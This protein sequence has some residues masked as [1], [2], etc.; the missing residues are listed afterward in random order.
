MFPATRVRCHDLANFLCRSPTLQPSGTPMSAIHH[1]AMRH[2]HEQMLARLHNCLTKAQRASLQLLAQRLSVAAG[3]NGRLGRFKLLLLC[4][5]GRDSV[6]ALIFL[7]AAQLHIAQRQPQTFQLRVAVWRQGGVGQNA[8]D[9]AL[10]AC[11][12][13][14][15]EGD[16]DVEL[17]AVDDQRIGPLHPSVPADDDGRRRQRMNM[18]VSGHLSGGHEWMTF[19]YGSYL[20]MAGCYWRASVWQ[21]GVDAVAIADPPRHLRHYLAWGMRAARQLSQPAARAELLSALDGLGSAYYQEL[22]GQGRPAA[23]G[24]SPACDAGEP[25]RAPAQLINLHDVLDGHSPDHWRLLVDFLDHQYLGQGSGFDDLDAISPLLLA[26]M[27]GLRSEFVAARSYQRG[28]HDHLRAA[29]PVM[30]SRGMPETMVRRALATWH[31]EA[32]LQRRRSQANL[33]AQAAFGVDEAQLVCLLFAPFVGHGAGLKGY[34][35]RCHPSL[36]PT[37]ADMHG[38]LQGLPACASTVAW[39]ESISGL[40]QDVLQRLYRLAPMNRADSGGVIAT[41]HASDPQQYAHKHLVALTGPQLRDLIAGR[42]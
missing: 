27:R 32:A 36:L 29:V 10:R 20:S 35:Q 25:P 13:L 7:R 34:L 33:Q 41:L 21:G 17:L 6:Q 4:A 22:H 16:P 8:Y 11:D 1:Q 3:G 15:L 12:A 18:L 31:G 38:A 24:K 37:L 5:G 2:V 14:F 30:R 39:L 28:V 9:N 26:H 19:G 23:Q 40:P 42:T